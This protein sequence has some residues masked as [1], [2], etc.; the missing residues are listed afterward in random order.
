MGCKGI[1]F[2][3]VRDTLHGHPV[4]VEAEIVEGAKAWTVS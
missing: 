2:D 4:Q 1:I 3:K